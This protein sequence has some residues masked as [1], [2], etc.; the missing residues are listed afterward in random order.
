MNILAAPGLILVVL[1]LVLV[2]MTRAGTWVVARRNPPAGT[3]A[4]V[5]ATRIH[6]VHV[7]A[8]ARADL[9]PVVFI[10]GASGNLKDQ[11]LPLRPLVQGRAELL[12]LDRPGHGWSSRGSGNGD[13]HG[14]AATIAALMDHLGIGEAII[15]GHSFGGAVA[16]TLALNHPEKARG[17]LFLAAATHPWPGGATSWYYRLAARPV[18]GR[19]F[20]E[21]LAYPAGRL[22]MRAAAACVFSPNQPP[23]AY[24]DDAGIGLVLRPA[25]FRANALDVEGLYR[26]VVKTAP[27][28]GEIDAP[29]IVIS[30]DR[31]SVVYEEIHSGGLARDIPRAEAVWVH[32]LGHKPDWIAP[33]L[34]LAAVEKLSGAE[35]DLQAAASLVEVRVANDAFAVAMCAS[36]KPPLAGLQ[37]ET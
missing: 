19:L 17:L 8:P 12:F 37:A 4:T 9:P 25:A 3:F 11:M 16:A 35:R 31:D 15:V 27:R 36:E 20:A 5:N 26:H 32:N 14:Q 24:L 18:L 21:T 1:V 22:R 2:G 29:A 34:V 7:P 33:E 30:G 6:Y 28:Y 10:H 13:L 23:E